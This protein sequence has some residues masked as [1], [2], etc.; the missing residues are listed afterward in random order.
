M[1]SGGGG[2]AW[3]E[4]VRFMDGFVLIP[5]P[6]R[7]VVR[8]SKSMLSLPSVRSL[9]AVPNRRVS[10]QC[11]TTKY[12]C[13]A[14]PPSI[15]SVPK[16]QVSV[17]CPTT[18][19]PCNAHPQIIPAVPNHQVSLQWPTATAEYSCSAQHVNIPATLGP[20]ASLQCSWQRI[21]AVP[22]PTVALQ[23][24]MAKCPCR[25]QTLQ[26]RTP[27]HLPLQY[28]SAIFLQ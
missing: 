27:Q 26:R 1:V 4:N 23:C 14:Q 18:K 11:P 13:S 17:Q 8:F 15:P 19:Y 28:Q 7:G 24:S 22:K 2:G 9:T 6:R 25:A 16:Q 12:P 10:L 21:P 20:T 5:H 3:L